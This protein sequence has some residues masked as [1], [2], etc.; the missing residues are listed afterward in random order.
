MLIEEARERGVR[1]RGRA[2]ADGHAAMAA[3]GPEDVDE[4]RRTHEIGE[5]QRCRGWN[6][7]VALADHVEDGHGEGL[8]ADPA[9]AERERAAGGAGLDREGADRAAGGR[10]GGYD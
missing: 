2:P 6:D 8:E 7:L 3:L 5:R 9:A 4:A 10:S 1:R